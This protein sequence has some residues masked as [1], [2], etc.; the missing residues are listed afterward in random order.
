MR[1]RERELGVGRWEEE[2]GYGHLYHDCLFRISPVPSAFG[3]KGPSSCKNPAPTD[4]HPG[5]AHSD[6]AAYNQTTSIIIITDPPI[7]ASSHPK[8]KRKEKRILHLEQKTLHRS[9]SVELSLSW[10]SCLLLCCRNRSTVVKLLYNT[11][12]NTS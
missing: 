6:T 10:R 2:E 11:K 12:P 5:P 1:E 4:E 8:K 9:S 7:H 3:E